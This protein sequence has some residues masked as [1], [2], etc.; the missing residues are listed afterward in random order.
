[1]ICQFWGTNK[2]ENALGSLPLGQLHGED[3]EQ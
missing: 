3:D 2:A 1:M